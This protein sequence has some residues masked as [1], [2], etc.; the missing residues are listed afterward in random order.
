MEYKEFISKTENMKFIAHR[1]GLE[2][3]K[4]PEN[5]INVLEEIFNNKEMLGS[6]YGF[7][8]DICFTKDNV[9]VVIHDK[10]IDD[11]SSGRGLV[12]SYTL[13]ELK[14]VNFTF[15]KSIN[16]NNKSFTFKIVALEEILDYFNLNSSL[17]GSR[18][19]QIESKDIVFFN[20]KNLS[21]LADIINKYPNLKNNIIHL[22]FYPYNLVLLKGIQKSH[23]YDITKSDLLCDY[24][25]MVMLSKLISSIDYVSLRIKTDNFPKVNSN[26]TNRVNRKIFSN[27]FFMKFSDAINEKT[28]KYVI[29]KCGNAYLYVLNSDYDINEFCN[30]VSSKFF[31]DNYDKLVF[32]TDNPLKIKKMK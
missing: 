21:S 2:M 28:L 24:K 12:K 26:N 8:F 32:T 9:P 30:R 17:L 31:E 29:N 16:G 27:T 13:K 22:S 10:Y 14:D 5:S 1:L 7:E 20:K 11:I 4:Y 6:L 18:V 25:V 15:R 19:I 23:N 3:T